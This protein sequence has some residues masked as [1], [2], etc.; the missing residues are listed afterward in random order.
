VEFRLVAADGQPPTARSRAS[1][2]TSPVKMLRLLD[3]DSPIPG[4]A[5]YLL[6]TCHSSYVAFMAP[7]LSRLLED[8]LLRQVGDSCGAGTT[9]LAIS[10]SILTHR[11]ESV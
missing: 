5:R 1:G 4:T 2:Y 7:P 10:S 9:R 11:E 8:L 3:A 6:L